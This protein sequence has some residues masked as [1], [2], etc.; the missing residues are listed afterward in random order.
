MKHSL[1]ITIILLLFFLSSQ[2]L[3]LAIVRSYIDVEKTI[4][5]G[6]VQWKPLLKVGKTELITRPEMQPKT[7]FLFILF[8]IL[9]GT[10]IVFLIIKLK[11][12]VLWKA[13]Y[14]LAVMAC[15]AIAFNAFIPTIIAI[16]L[17]IILASLKLLRPSIIIHNAT[18]VFVYGGLIAIFAP[19]FNLSW[20][21]LL[22]IAISIYDIYAVWRSKHMIKLAKAQTKAKIFAG[23]LIPYKM[24]AMKTIKIEHRQKAEKKKVK[25][26]AAIIGGGDIGF[27]LLFAST[28][29]KEI[30]FVHALITVIA[31]TAALASLF[32]LGKKE[33]YYPAMP[34]LTA[35]CFAG[36]LLGA[37]IF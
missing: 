13:W 35:G 2:L 4:E 20:A 17:A 25:A 8:A 24:P 37:S 19:I 34:F 15:L 29:M 36:L 33:R 11:K 18:E 16:I 10:L 5:T 31:A 22:L 30:G 26:R 12:F 23:L 27:T 9:I 28:I 32:L 3:G 21:S 7:G 6:T 1:K 14:F